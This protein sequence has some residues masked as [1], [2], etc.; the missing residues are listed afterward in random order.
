MSPEPSS[1]EVIVE[2]ATETPTAGRVA[3]L[4]LEP[5]SALREHPLNPRTHFDEASLDELA[6]SI[7]AQ[8]V[9]NP[10]LVRPAT[11]GP[12]T[13]EIL[14]GARRFRAAK[15]AGLTEVPVLVRA[16]SDDAALE[17]MIIDNLQRKDVHPL[18]EAAGYRQLMSKAK[19]EVQ[20]IADRVGRSV[21]Y[22]YDRVKLLSLTKAAQ[23]EFLSGG[24]SAGHAILLARLSPADQERALDMDNAALWTTQ[25]VMYDPREKNVD[26]LETDA[27]A[28]KP[29]SVREFAD[30]I[31]KNVRF[32]AV[33]PDPML[34]PEAA[35]VLTQAREEEEKVVHITLDHY[36]TPEA[37]EDGKRTYGPASWKR[38]DGEQKSKPC[39]HSVTGVIVVGPG[40]GEA[41]KVCVDKKKCAVHWGSEQRQA[42]QRA[43]AVTTG[44]SSGEDRYAIEERK[45]KEQQA[46]EDA[47]RE[48][49][50]KAA[51]AIYAAV[52]ER[53]K[54]AAT[55]TRGVL[56]QILIGAV[57]PYGGVRG[58]DAYVPAGSSVEDL[59]RHAAF[60]VLAREMQG[61]QAPWEFPKRAKAFGIDVRKILDE[62]APLPKPEPKK[63]ADKPA[64]KSAK[65]KAGRAQATA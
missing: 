42:K 2:T 7:K 17:L 18:E 58:V 51:P 44:G 24:F 31:D 56:G 65:R 4:R 45:R 33:A 59:V 12:A 25:R 55:G 49:W 46:R 43:K 20:A 5:L 29:V 26:R 52:A 15:K 23:Q 36:V 50:K 21:K 6:A 62:A 35:Q 9:I 8:G 41:F 22:I 3:A 40:R 57:T 10:L 48:R 61:W 47:Q 54:K 63:A 28:V 37:K 1:K 27:T 16:V 38:A 53:V 64:P 34:F 30:W 32:E 39:E 19:L 11:R 13:Y 60:I 14:G